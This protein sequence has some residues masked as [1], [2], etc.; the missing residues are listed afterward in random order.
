KGLAAGAAAGAAVDLATGGL[1]LGA[2]TV[3]GAAVGGLWQ[4]AGRFGERWLG[5]LKGGR[6]LTVDDGV[7]RALALRQLWLARALAARGHAAQQP[8]ALEAAQDERWRKGPLPP[9]LRDARGHPE[10]SS[11]A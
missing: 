3:V 11:L 8:L 4:T 7:L 9:A 5:R 6:E 10:W 1:S 2:G